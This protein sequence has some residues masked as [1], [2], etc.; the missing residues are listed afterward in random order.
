V[1]DGVFHLFAYGTLRRDGGQARILEGCAP[2]RDATVAGTLY[3]IDGRFP[4]LVLYGDTPVRG[5][6]WRCP[7]DRLLVLDEYEGVDAGLFRRVG[8]RVD[9]T[10]C[11]TYVAGPALARR[12]TAD[13]RIAS[14]DWLGGDRARGRTATRAGTAG[15]RDDARR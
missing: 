3:D 7:A 5:E 10:A 15:D 8:L 14:G 4:A 2:V 13:R 9:D 1:T 11:W 12:L 6:I